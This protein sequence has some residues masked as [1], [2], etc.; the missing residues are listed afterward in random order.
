ML[1]A[2]SV[3]GHAFSRRSALKRS[4]GVMA[5]LSTTAAFEAIAGTPAPAKAAVAASSATTFSDIQYNIGQFFAPAQSLNNGGGAVTVQFPPTFALIQP[6]KLNRTPTTTDQTT[7]ANALNTIEQAFSASPSGLLFQS[8]GYGIPYFNRLK[9]SVVTANFPTTHADGKSPLQEAIAFPTDVVGGLVGGPNAVVPNVTKSRFNVNVQIEKNDLVIQTRSNILANLTNANLWLQGSNNLNGVFHASP[10]F[11]GLFSFQTAR[12]QFVKQG[13]PKQVAQANNLEFADRINSFS[14]MA[15][16]FI[17][18]QTNAAGPAAITTFAGNSSA[19]LTT[20]KAG[21]YF[22]NAGIQHL[23]HDIEDLFAFYATATQQPNK[24][25][26]GE[27]F[28]EH[29]QY[30]FQS[31]TL[32]TTNGLPDS[33]V[34]NSDQFTNGGGPALFANVFQG[35]GAALAA[36]QDSAG[37]FTANNATLNATFTGTPRIGHN[38]ALQQFSRASDGTPLHIRA[39]GPG[40]DSLD[41]PAFNTAGTG[42]SAGVFVTKGTNV[43]AGSNQFKL[44]FTI[45]V[46]TAQLFQQMRTAQAAQNL[47]AEF[48]G[49]ESSDNGL[50]RFITSTRRQNFVVPPRRHRSFPLTELNG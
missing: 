32:G 25:P 11:N 13:M 46:P 2:E 45:Y 48:L 44:Q 41:V 6:I 16:S 50:E 34:G 28:T 14:S 35:T 31:N 9:Q 12:V 24:T 36:A 7:F 30:M 39:D 5:L 21:D 47:M 26:A 33:N 8:I 18:Q 40:F 49:G 10:N 20:A 1:D 15:M 17:D 27:P 38:A 29:V 42:N 37:Q 19:V 3:A 43:P 4:A 22:D 23:S